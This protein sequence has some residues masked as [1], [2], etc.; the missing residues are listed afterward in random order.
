MKK[1]VRLSL[2][3]IFLILVGTVM[4]YPL[5]WLAMSSFKTNNE[6]L[7]G[8][9]LLPENP[10]VSAYIEGWKGSGQVGFSTFFLNSVIMTVP[11]VIFSVISSVLVAY[12]FSRFE[13]G[14][15]RVLF[16][17]MLSTLM[18]PSSVL[19]I[20]RY[21]MFRDLGW[22]D[23]Y[24]PFWVPALCA[25]Q[26]FFNFLLVQ[27]MRNIPRELDD[28]ALIDGCNSW[29]TLT[30]VILPLCK[31]AIF[32]V[33]LFAFMWT[34]NDFTN[35]LIYISSVKK[36]PLSLG[37]RISMDSIG[38]A[39][40]PEIMAMSLVSILPPILLFFFTQKYFVD[41]IVTTGIKG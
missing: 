16:G 13:F 15:R 14:G 2:T 37:L 20:P 22:L 12:G 33:G 17:L 35:S 19:I 4:I 34:W 23:T 10:S 26:T 5:V 31:P 25:T 18:L 27:F 11:V 36:Y 32:S 41:S 3:H 30:K 28:A 29:T 38:A 21:L 39:N 7:G 8:L 24:L 40:W 6:I 9:S 1:N